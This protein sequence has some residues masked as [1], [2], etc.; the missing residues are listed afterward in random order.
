M[1]FVEKST[2]RG[3]DPTPTHPRAAS[4]SLSMG[5]SGEIEFPSLPTVGEARSVSGH[6]VSDAEKAAP[7]SPQGAGGGKI[8]IIAAMEREIQPLVQGWKTRTIEQLGRV[9]R[10]FESGNTTVICGG[11]GGE[12]ARRATE[13]LIKETS[14]TKILSVG[15][16]GA[17]DKALHVG[18]IVTPRFTINVSD[19]SR[20]ENPDGRGTLVTAPTVATAAQKLSYS[21]AYEAAAVDMEGAA[22]AQGAQA[23]GIDFA[24]IKVIS[25]ELD[26]DMPSFDGFVSVEGKF[27]TAQFALHMALRPWLWKTAIVLARNSS[28]ASIALSAAL[29]DFIRREN[30]TADPISS[31]S[32]EIATRNRYAAAHSVGEVLDHTEIKGNQ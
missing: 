18:D 31:A 15:L 19:G 14:P 7:K 17:L 28:K 12:A 20:S 11:I 29:A 4:V 8:A 25:D 23:H 9:Y 13:A 5:N 10:I 16:A 6:R 1:S 26:F 24:A 22:V 30:Q 27:K 32:L 21:K 3:N 2:F